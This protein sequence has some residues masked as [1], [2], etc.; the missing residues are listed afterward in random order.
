MSKDSTAILAT[1]A[2]AKRSLRERLRS[3]F[4][5]DALDLLRFRGSAEMSAAEE[6]VSDQDLR[7]LLDRALFAEEPGYLGIDAVFPAESLVI[8]AVAPDQKVILYRRSYTLGDDTSVSLAAEKEAV[9]PVTRYEPVNVTAAAGVESTTTTTTT[10][11]TAP[12]TA[13]SCGCQ[14]HKGATSAKEEEAMPTPS[15]AERVLA[16]TANKNSRLSGLDPALF[17]GLAEPAVKALEEEAAKPPTETPPATPTPPTTP[18]TP[19][20]PTPTPP[21]EPTTASAPPKEPTEDEWLAKAPAHLRAMVTEHKAAEAARRATFIAKLKAA[22]TAYTEEQLAAKTTEDLALLSTALK[23]D[24][25]A[26]DFS[27]RGLPVSSAAT[28]AASLPDTYGLNKAKSTA[29]AT[30]GKEA[31]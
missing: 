2:T 31:N 6:S 20:A 28:R 24:V 19:T 5:G 26:R 9:E 13:A 25:P 10:P 1:P 21:A 16:L 17:A 23:L 7:S 15:I 27:G 4:T 3:L 29:T 12:I 18:T 30:A 14:T 11:T 22:Q 8:Y